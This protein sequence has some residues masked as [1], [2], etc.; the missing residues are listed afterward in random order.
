MNTKEMH[1]KE[2]KEN[3]VCFVWISS[4]NFVSLLN[5]NTCG[6]FQEDALVCTSWN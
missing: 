5:L 2:H 4:V 1:H 6:F 3:I